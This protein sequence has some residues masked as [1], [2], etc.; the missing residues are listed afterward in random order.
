MVWVN[1]RTKVFHRQ[2]DRWY[3]KTKNGKYMTEADAVAA[4]YRASKEK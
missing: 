4:G 2:G 3:G 1:P